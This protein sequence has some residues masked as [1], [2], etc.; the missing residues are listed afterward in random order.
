MVL[1]V[2]TL[3]TRPNEALKQKISELMLQQRSGAGLKMSREHGGVDTL[4]QRYA[5]GRPSVHPPAQCSTSACKKTLWKRRRRARCSP[6]VISSPT[7]SG[8][9][10][11]VLG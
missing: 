3:A 4:R 2:P 6:M 10:T 9:S 1:G 8:V 5:R 11:L 7:T